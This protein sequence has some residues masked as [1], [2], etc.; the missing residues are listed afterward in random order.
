MKIG[1]PIFLIVL[2]LVGVGY[3]SSE[4]L[5]QTEEIRV[6]KEQ[7]VNL[8]QDLDTERS[9]KNNALTKIQTLTEDIA[10]LQEMLDTEQAKNQEAEIKIQKLMGEINNLQHM[11][12]MEQTKNQETEAKIQVLET[13]IET[14]EASLIVA[15]DSREYY[16]LL[17]NMQQSSFSLVGLLVTVLVTGSAALFYSLHTILRRQKL[18]QQSLETKNSPYITV[19]MTRQQA[20]DYIR[21]QRKK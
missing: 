16:P 15:P 20:K 10:K 13:Q 8:Q 11:I 2:L 21:W 17:A 3:L 14:M 19:R 18:S 12:A 6:L 7:A 9:A 5:H 4:T 1:T